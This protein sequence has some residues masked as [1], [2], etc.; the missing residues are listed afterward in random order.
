ME[1]NDVVRMYE[2]ATRKQEELAE[3]GDLMNL[4]YAGQL[5]V[6]GRLIEDE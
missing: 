3:A 5:S 1:Q 4:F 6:L 2:N